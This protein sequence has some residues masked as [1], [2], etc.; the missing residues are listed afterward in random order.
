MAALDVPE[1]VAKLGRNCHF[2][3]ALTT[4][5][6]V[7]LHME[8]LAA[9][10]AAAAAAPSLGGDRQALMAAVGGMYAQGVQAAIREGGCCASRA[11]YVGAVLGAAAAGAGA[12]LPQD[13]AKKYAAMKQ[14]VLAAQHLCDARHV[15][16]L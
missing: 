9:A 6:H 5:L 12:P 4:P 16:T 2:P 3:N 1:A 13:W 11:S 8:H 7:V 10:A 15:M 14:V